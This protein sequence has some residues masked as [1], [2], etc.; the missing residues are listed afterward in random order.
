V[1]S[2]GRSCCFGDQIVS[3][4]RRGIAATGGAFGVEIVFVSAAST[5]IADAAAAAIELF[6][7][8]VG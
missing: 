1:L 4:K 7:F 8:E 6:F 3:I 5:T 2:I